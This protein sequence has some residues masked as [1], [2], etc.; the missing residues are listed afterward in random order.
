MKVAE[1]YMGVIIEHESWEQIIPRYDSPGVFIYCDPPYP[2]ATRTNYKD[3]M[4]NT[5][6]YAKRQARKMGN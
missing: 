4:S 2:M 3:E 6:R 1:Q 5:S